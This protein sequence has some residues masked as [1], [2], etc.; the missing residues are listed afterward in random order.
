MDSLLQKLFFE[1]AIRPL[2]P[3]LESVLKYAKGQLNVDK[4]VS[5]ATKSGAALSKAAQSTH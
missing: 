4:I 2:D 3:E 1:V 5:E